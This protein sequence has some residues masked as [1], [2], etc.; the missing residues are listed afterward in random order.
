MVFRFVN[1]WQ[2]SL[3]S[4][5]PNRDDKLALLE[6]RD[7]DLE[8]ELDRLSKALVEYTYEPTI[9]ASGTSPTGWT[10]TGSYQLSGLRCRGW[11]RF[12]YGAGTAAVG[13]LR[14]GLPFTAA[15]TVRVIGVGCANDSGTQN[16]RGLLAIS[17]YAQMH[18]EAGAAVT[19]AAPMTPGASDYYTIVF[20]YVV[21]L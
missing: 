15:S 21:A 6:L 1:R 17:D 3:A 13:T 7:R 9:A 20:D 14:F 11:A 18:S 4:L 5:F 10:T 19:G 12:D 8:A 16:M 2:D